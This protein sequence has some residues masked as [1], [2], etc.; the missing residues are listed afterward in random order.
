MAESVG[1]HLVEDV[2]VQMGEVAGPG[3]ASKL[4]PCRVQYQVMSMSELRG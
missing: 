1:D 3:A 4:N 2:L